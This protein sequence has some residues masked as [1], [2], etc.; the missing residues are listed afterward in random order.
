MSGC[1]A[2]MLQ[3]PQCCG[4]PEGGA[5]GEVR[6]EE[7]AAARVPPSSAGGMGNQA[8]AG[9]KCE[10][11]GLSQHTNKHSKPSFVSFVNSELLPSRSKERRHCLIV[12]GFTLCSC[13]SVATSLGTRHFRALLYTTQLQAEATAT[14]THRGHIS[15]PQRRQLSLTYVLLICRSEK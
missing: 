13:H 10:A 4:S 14:G 6:S 5:C 3:T 12:G 1:W 11:P 9:G 15:V 2:G 7:S 8:L